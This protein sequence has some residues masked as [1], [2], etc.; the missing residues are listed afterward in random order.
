MLQC[1]LKIQLHHLITELLLL[2]VCP[3]DSVLQYFIHFVQI[4]IFLSDHLFSSSVMMPCASLINRLHYSTHTS[5]TLQSHAFFGL[6]LTK[7][8]IPLTTADM[9]KDSQREKSLRVMTCH[10][11]SS[12]FE[13]ELSLLEVITTSNACGQM[14]LT[15]RDTLNKQ[16]LK[17]KRFNKQY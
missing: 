15:V 2:T 8:Y 12:E 10:F 11:L 13:A 1:L 4:N 9:D 14:H 6:Q 7:S 5:K 17:Y 16:M 3:C